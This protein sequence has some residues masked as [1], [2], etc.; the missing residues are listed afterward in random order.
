[1]RNEAEAPGGASLVFLGCWCEHGQFK[2]ASHVGL[3]WGSRTGENLPR[4]IL[5]IGSRF[6]KR[7]VIAIGTV[8]IAAVILSAGLY[9]RINIE[10]DQIRYLI[11]AFCNNPGL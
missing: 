7:R 5:I 9:I 1:M 8:I 10:A 2:S 6:M 3:C 11:D 4:N